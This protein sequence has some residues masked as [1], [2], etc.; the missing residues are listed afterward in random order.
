MSDKLKKRLTFAIA[1]LFWVLYSGASLYLLFVKSHLID[2]QIIDFT[3]KIFFTF[4]VVALFFY[5]RYAISKA[6]SLN[7]TDLLWKVFITGLITTLISLSIQFLFTVFAQSTITENPFIVN[8]FYSVLVGLVVVFTMSTL[9][10]WKRLIL[11]QKT[12]NLIQLWS[13][14]QL[15]LAAALIFDFL[16]QSIDDM[17][18]RIAL[19]ILGCFT[20]ILIFN[21]KWIA[22]LNFKQK[23]KSML[24]ILLAG[25][26]LYHLLLNLLRFSASGLLI[27]DLF[28]HVFVWA[29]FLFLF[30]YSGITI[31]V[32]LF[33][34]P[35]SSVFEQKLKEALDF[36][37]L[38]QSIPR[39]E[40]K[41][42][43][44]EILLGS[45]M[46]AVF[47]DAAWLEV[48]EGGTYN[49]LIR[50]LKATEIQ[51]IK[52][53][54]T[55]GPVCDV[56]QYK[57]QHEGNFYKLSD[58]LK[59]PLYKSILVLPIMIKDKQE[60][61]IVLLN[62]VT[63]AF[64]K[65][66]TDILTTFVN[67]A[68]IS[69]ENLELINESLETERYRE[70][71]NIAKAVQQSLLPSR[72]I[73]NNKLSIDA[74]SEA[75]DE[76]GGDYYDF[77]SQSD[78]KFDLII[79]DVSGK[80]TS[81]AFHMAQ[82]KGVFSSLASQKM[83]PKDFII[84]ANIALSK[85]LDRKS[86]V[87]A[88]YFSIDTEEKK[89]EMSRAG[90]CPTL[91]FCKKE[92]QVNFLESDG[93]G[94]G[95]LRNSS[96]SN[97]VESITIGYHPGDVMLLYTDGI[98]EAK[99]SEGELFGGERLKQSFLKHSLADSSRIKEGISEDLN[100]FMGDI[101]IDDDYTLVVVGFKE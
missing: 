65:E 49:Q 40:T 79:G 38:S 42:Q 73:E 54:I 37:R 1:L 39:G 48:N 90:H 26:Y 19:I 33:N 50:N 5:F 86:F 85:C 80:G 94:L 95:M 70:Q 24:F 64:N 46:S 69:L 75:A 71:L 76:V 23:L 51:D 91:I 72:L 43:T 18:F 87:T 96:Y 68:S 60:G 62:E 13:I 89:V 92:S 7:F 28:N 29:V 8:F 100:R 30:L 55:T 27:M 36:Q 14:F 59:H 63:D 31:L 81:A 35:T 88:T 93:M 25:I 61:Y 83:S 101:E 53:K 17:G 20:L 45:A 10:V 47:A 22:Y 3:P 21:L 58:R 74:L 2:A 44:Y 11:Y 57:F 41:D 16:P 12:K 99:N 32:T 34:L 78:S 98:I 9:V 82:V 67:Q 15:A 77:M 66:M 97:Y 52:S 84:Q 56:I 4:F 6:D